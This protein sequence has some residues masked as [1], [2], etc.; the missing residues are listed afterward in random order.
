[1]RILKLRNTEEEGERESVSFKVKNNKKSAFP[2]SKQREKK[3]KKKHIY[4]FP[5]SPPLQIRLSQKNKPFNI[6][7]KTFSSIL[8]D[9][10]SYILKK[11]K[12]KEQ[13]K[14]L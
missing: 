3:K 2:A 13:I 7:L 14:Y 1:M 6:P 5:L 9:T 10:G 8:I 12:I 4:H 11:L